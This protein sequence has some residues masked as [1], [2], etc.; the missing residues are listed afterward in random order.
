MKILCLIS[1]L[2]LP[3]AYALDKT[4]VAIEKKFSLERLQETYRKQPSL[5]ADFIQEVYQATLAR[6]KTSMGRLQLAKPSLIRWEVHEP[7]ASVM[8]SNGR[9][10]FYF[11]PNARG[12]GKGQ[13]IEKSANELTRQPL[14]RILTGDVPLTKEFTVLKQ[15]KV[16]GVAKDESLTFIELKPKKTMGD[17]ANLKLRV[18]AKYLIRELILENVNGNSTKITLQN[19]TLGDKL[20]P[21]LFDFKPPEGTEILRN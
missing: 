19:Q 13:V 9:K 6:T 3:S 20:P 15:E 7:E 17:I 5:Q 2:V 11:T 16:P 21:A 4:K 1:L 12:P 18:D 14:F 8:V 10:V